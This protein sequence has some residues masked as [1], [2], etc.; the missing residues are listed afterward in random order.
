MP[1]LPLLNVVEIELLIEGS[2]SELYT[3][4]TGGGHSSIS[5][6]LPLGSNTPFLVQKVEE[7]GDGGF[8]FQVVHSKTN[9]KYYAF[10]HREFIVCPA[11]LSEVFKLN[12]YACLEIE[13]RPNYYYIFIDPKNDDPL[14][15]IS[16]NLSKLTSTTH[17]FDSTNCKRLVLNSVNKDIQ[18]LLSDPEI[19]KC[20]ASFIR[21]LW[22][23]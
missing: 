15:F 13:N 9:M 21:E 7:S 17:V 8:V 22:R 20:S 16:N 2:R 14:S 5:D 3:K 10:K 18:F 23:I 4:F 6:P 11:F 1:Y 19:K 12:D